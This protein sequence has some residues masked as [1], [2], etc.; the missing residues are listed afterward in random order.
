MPRAIIKQMKAFVICD[1]E[2][3]WSGFAYDNDCQS[4][5][6]RRFLKPG[7]AAEAGPDPAIVDSARDN[8]QTIVT[9]NGEDFIRYVREAQ[10]KENLKRCE[11]C[12][13][14]SSCRTRTISASTL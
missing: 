8:C 9:S 6:V 13:G 4:E 3:Q 11:D 2:N 7:E 5:V 12:W 14:W 10:K 1:A